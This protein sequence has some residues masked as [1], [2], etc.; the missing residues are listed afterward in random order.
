MKIY[1]YHLPVFEKR[2]KKLS[3]WEMLVS[4]KA[5]DPICEGMDVL[6][7]EGDESHLVRLRQMFR[8]RYEYFR[9]SAEFVEKSPVQIMRYVLGLPEI[10]PPRDDEWEFRIAE[11][12]VNYRAE[13]IN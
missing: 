5:N 12:T 13:K 1:I 3:G 9:D 10:K 6:S 7:F 4:V 8:Q 11:W 2:S